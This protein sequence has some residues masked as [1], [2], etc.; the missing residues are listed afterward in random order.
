LSGGQAVAYALG[1]WDGLE[2][3]LSHGDIEIDNNGVENAI[4]PTAV[5]KRNWLFI[6][7]P[8]AGSKSAT[9]YSLLGSCLRRSLN[10]REYICWLL[11]RLPAATNHTV[12]ELTPAAYAAALSKSALN[13]RR[14]A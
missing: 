8:Q 11:E 6:G 10:P 12:H 9:L 1:Q 7:A 3:F 13:D 14:T 5:G 2:V 4:R